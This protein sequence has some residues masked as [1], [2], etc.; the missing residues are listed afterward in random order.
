MTDL[1]GLEGGCLCGEVRYRATGQPLWVCH[2][3][4][5]MCQKHTGAAFS[6]FIGFSSECISWT[7]REP[8]LYQSSTLVERGFCPV[9][10]STTSFHRAHK[11]EVSVSAGSLDYPERIT[12]QFHLMT[13]SQVPWINLCDDLPTH[14]RFPP[15]G[16]DRDVDL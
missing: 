9:C 13:E 8:N 6:T 3:H 11:S 14:H 10:G 16:E 1:P 4:C 12:P 15:E 2:C 7:K 5:R